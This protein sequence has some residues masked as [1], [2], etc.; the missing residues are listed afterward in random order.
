MIKMVLR[1]FDLERGE[2]VPLTEQEERRFV[3]EVLDEIFKE[4]GLNVSVRYV[5]TPKYL[6]EGRI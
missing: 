2:W 6:R 4:H 5:K 3:D 1:K